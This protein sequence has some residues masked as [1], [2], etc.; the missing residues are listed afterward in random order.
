MSESV[1]P[2]AEKDGKPIKYKFDEAFQKA[3]VISAL[4]DENFM[5]RANGLLLP[6]HFDSTALALSCK[7]AKDF[8]ERYK[9][10]LNDA[11]V[12]T[13]LDDYIDKHIFTKEE[14]SEVIPILKEAYS[15][16]VSLPPCDALIDH[17]VEF[18]RS[19]A[20]TASIYESVELIDKRDW[21]TIEKKLKEALSV[22]AEDEVKS[23]DYF[24]EIKK[25]TETRKDIESGILPPSGITTG[26]REFDECL[27]HK[28]W[29]RKELSLMMGTAKSGKSLSLLFFGQSAC[30]KGYNVLYVT[31]EV[32][33]RIISDR[34]DACISDT[35]MKDLVSHS[36]TVQRKIESLRDKAVATR[37]DIKPQ[38]GLFHI[39]EY[40]SGTL[41]V[42][43]LKRY[44]ESMREKG[45]Q[46][47][48]ICL[49]YADLMAPEQR[50][51]NITE[52]FRTIYVDLRALA[53]EFNVAMLTATQTN[54][55]GSKSKVAEM[56]HVAEDFNKVRTAD[57]VISINVSQ[58]EREKGEARLYFVASRNSES[59]LTITVKQNVSK[60]QFITDV[61]K[62]EGSRASKTI[63]S[64]AGPKTE[65]V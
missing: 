36:L 1:I 52:N 35:S 40:P 64:I 44:L 2:V 62:V 12:R 51:T 30:L 25:R 27:Y 8:Y 61:V 37:D 65:E 34:I 58:E 11:L 24:E 38:V 17:L 5:R 43:T 39:R 54:R 56:E 49:D 9:T 42:S 31:L 46:Y 23:Y 20:V 7:V 60:M 33:A 18:A 15:P 45:V 14:V 3:L 32:S 6:Q 63:G 41:K 22:G 47:D 59:G 21:A 13:T 19:S 48:L 53:F 28:G 50:S 16:T 10:V 4:R 29:G 26:C 55:E 57:I